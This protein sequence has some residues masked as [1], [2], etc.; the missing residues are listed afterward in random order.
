[1]TLAI[2]ILRTASSL[3]AAARRAF[4]DLDVSPAQF[5]VLNIV[6]DYEN[7]VSFTEVADQLLVDRS[8]VTLLVRR[9]VS[10]GLLGVTPSA[11]DGRQKILQLTPAG[12][13]LW[14]RADKFYQEGLAKIAKSLGAG[15][16]NAIMTGLRRI[17]ELAN[18]LH[19]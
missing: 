18:E 10:D 8:N 1:M 9:L 16:V 12:R 6:S 5:N 2:Q 3:E 7:G 4:K 19:R 11:T 15:E 17:E 14:K 13:K